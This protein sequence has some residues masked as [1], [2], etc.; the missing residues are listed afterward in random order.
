VNKTKT[1]FSVH[2]KKLLIIS[3]LLLV[4]LLLTSA[5]VYKLTINGDKTSLRGAVHVG[6]EKKLRTTIN[7]TPSNTPTI[8]ALDSDISLSGSALEIPADKDITLVSDKRDGFWKL[9]GAANQPTIH[10]NGKLTIEGIIVTHNDGVS[11]RGVTV[12]FGGT[13]IMSDGAICNNTI[14]MFDDYTFWEW[15][16]GGVWNCGSFSMYGGEISNNTVPSDGGGVANN[17]YDFTMYGGKIS[18]NTASSYG[19]GVF[20]NNGQISL[21]DGVISD[22]TAKVGGGAYI[23]YGSFVMSGGE[24]SGNAAEDKGG[25]VYNYYYSRFSLSGSGEIS[26]NTAPLGDGVCND[27]DFNRNGGVLSGNTVYY[28]DGALSW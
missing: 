19:G 16:G 22:N 24:I 26:N 7:N 8:I 25:G 4:I 14:T 12:N 11:G 6:N 2:H 5:F 3:S 17:G 15:Q 20:N 28:S 23:H 18:N 1:K 13:L 21:C 10:V 9:I 27:G